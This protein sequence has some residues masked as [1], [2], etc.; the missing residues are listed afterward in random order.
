MA[1]GER[2]RIFEMFLALLSRKPRDRPVMVCHI[3]ALA[4]GSLPTWAGRPSHQVTTIPE[5][6]WIG[7][8]R[9][10]LQMSHVK[11]KDW[12]ASGQTRSA[13]LWR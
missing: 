9:D 6:V 10:R 12:L 2:S 4:A 7:F 8:F 11:L 5:L 13:P 3:S 1:P